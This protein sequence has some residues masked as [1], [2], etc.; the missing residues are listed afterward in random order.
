MGDR[1]EDYGGVGESA[2]VLVA[3]VEEDAVDAELVGDFEIVGSV[4]D[5]QDR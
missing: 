3:V 2:S 5:H 4:A 1:I